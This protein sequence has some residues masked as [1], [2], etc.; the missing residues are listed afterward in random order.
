MSNESTAHAKAILT[1]FLKQCGGAQG[2]LLELKYGYFAKEQPWK[3]QLDL[4]KDAILSAQTAIEQIL[5]EIE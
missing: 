3:D 1:E 5:K 2:A 4:M